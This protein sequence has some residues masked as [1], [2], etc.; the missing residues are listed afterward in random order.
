MQNRDGGVEGAVKSRGTAWSRSGAARS[1][2]SWPRR[3]FL[4]RGDLR[5]QAA[6]AFLHRPMAHQCR[7]GGDMAARRRCSLRRPPCRPDGDVGAGGVA[8]PAPPSPPASP[9]FFFFPEQRLRQGHGACALRSSPST[10][11]PFP[12]LSEFAAQQEEK[13]HGYWTGAAAD[14]GKSPMGGGAGTGRCG[15]GGFKRAAP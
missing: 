7:P 8:T 3:R 13:P 1:M 9:F 11:S 5:L 4:E 2:A 12:S 14:L 10:P 6:A 15:W